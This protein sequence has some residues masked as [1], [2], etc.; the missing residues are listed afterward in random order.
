MKETEGHSPAPWKRDGFG[1]WSSH[2]GENRMVAECRHDSGHGVYRP[3]TEGE[4][5]ANAAHIVRACNAYDDMLA[6]LENMTISFSRHPGNDDER[7]HALVMAYAAIRKAK[8][9]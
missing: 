6:A 2:N 4:S 5:L 7:R 3:K 9:E 8:G 1:V